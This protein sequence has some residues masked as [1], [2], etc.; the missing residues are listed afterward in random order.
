MKGLGSSSIRTRLLLAFVGVLVP[1]LALAGLGAVAF[2]I[3]WQRA[4]TTHE[5]VLAEMKGAAG[6]QVA[7]VQLV[8]P[9]ND[10]LITGDPAERGE[11][12]RRL[13]RAREVLSRLEQGHLAHPEERRVLAEVRA[14]LSGMEAASR[15]I[16]VVADPR[17]DSSLVGKMKALDEAGD[18]V[19][20]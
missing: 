2:R 1:Y 13:A 5:E 6:L 7:V 14:R 18:E 9:A 11:F 16:L 4:E 20:A 10:Y 12:E 3:V 15:A 8:M 17:R 19:A